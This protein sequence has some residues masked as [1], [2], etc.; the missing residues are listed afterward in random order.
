VIS[1]ALRQLSNKTLLKF[2]D[3]FKKKIKIKK[4]FV[5]SHNLVFDKDFFS[6]G[7]ELPRLT[8]M[9]EMLYDFKNKGNLNILECYKKLLDSKDIYDFII[10]DT[11]NGMQSPNE[12]VVNRILSV[13][14]QS[15]YNWVMMSSALDKLSEDGYLFFIV[16]ESI[17]WSEK[18]K[19]FLD[20]LEMKDC[21]VSGIINPPPE[22]RNKIFAIGSRPK[23]IILIFSKKRNEKLFIAEMNY[24]PSIRSLSDYRK[25]INQAKNG[26]QAKIGFK[27]NND[28][29]NNIISN[30][31]ENKSS[32]DIENGLW[33]HRK[34]FFTFDFFKAQKEIKALI[35]KNTKKY[36]ISDIAKINKK[37]SNENE[38]NSIYLSKFGRAVLS[39]YNKKTS[40]I[41]II[42]DEKKI[43]SNYLSLFYNS[44]LGE[45]ILESHKVGSFRQKHINEKN[46]IDSSVVYAPDIPV[47]KK[48]IN[49]HK[50]LKEIEEKLL[51]YRKD[52]EINPK[53]VNKVL[54]RIDQIDS[55]LSALS[56][57][58]EVLALI[59]QKESKT[60]ELKESFIIDTQT[61]QM[62][63]A[64]IYEVLKTINAF[65]NTNDGKLII[66]VSDDFQI[67]G[68]EK[69]SF[70]NDDQYLTR[71][72]NF[73]TQSIKKAQSGILDN[74]DAKIVEIEGKK[75]MVV[76]V[77]VDTTEELVGFKSKYYDEK[78][79]TDYKVLYFTRQIA[80]SKRLRDEEIVSYS[81]NRRKKYKI[82][83]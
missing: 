3:D 43:L 79:W 29:I 63:P 71:F 8:A 62:N 21:Y 82:K 35:P 74:V 46:F 31:F 58:N 11:P 24:I 72:N 55:A 68:I 59:R 2:V 70:K 42:V 20:E 64:M 61:K 19:S 67:K 76:D 47:Q 7:G 56:E 18:G 60:V 77:K 83:S 14:E 30:F 80:A 10:C 15:N 49:A 78:K 23:S 37:A 13:E 34:D 52:V 9:Q 5:L 51:K 69:D 26:Y 22:H 75:V 1:Y 65:L 81:K 27:I 44:R 17:T 39:S 28:G 12:K 36:P 4:E 48:T 33:V 6:K 16:E 73:L 40:F 38:K 53:D 32:N 66:G 54:E 41:Q 50:R 25:I 57:E 45:I